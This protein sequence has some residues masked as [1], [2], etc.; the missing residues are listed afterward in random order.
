[1]LIKAYSDAAIVAELC[2]PLREA[3]SRQQALTD[4]LSPKSKQELQAEALRNRI[5]TLEREVSGLNDERAE[6]IALAVRRAKEA[7]AREH[8]RDDERQ[9]AEIKSALTRAEAEFAAKL[10]TDC[11]ALARSIACQAFGRLA[12]T[13][14]EDEDWL[15]R[16]VLR[17]I[18]ELGANAVLAVRV[19][20]SDFTGDRLD[21]LRAVLPSGMRIVTDRDIPMGTARIELRLGEVPI[22]P[23]IGVAQLSQLISQGSADA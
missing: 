2:L 8:I 20:A 5:V 1:M 23:D 17:R 7:A 13:R 11:L 18:E 14:Q 10:E 3:E 12:K 16:L 22:E 21:A 15:G 9:F 6:A 19:P 4:G